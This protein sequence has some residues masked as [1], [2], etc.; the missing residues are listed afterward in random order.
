MKPTNKYVTLSC[1]TLTGMAF[2]LVGHKS[3]SWA[4]KREGKEGAE[5]VFEVSFLQHIL[6]QEGW[7]CYTAYPFRLNWHASC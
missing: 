5:K 7:Y 1:S 6:L 2:F 4:T 3:V